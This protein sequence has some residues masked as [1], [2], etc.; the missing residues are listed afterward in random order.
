M[1]SAPPPH[2]PARDGVDGLPAQPEP[3]PPFERLRSEQIYDSRWCGMRRD[4]LRLPSG[5]E[6]EYHVIEITDAVAVVPI[7]AD[8]RIAMIGQY[9]YP[10]G[11]THWEI[12][13]GRMNPSEEPRIAAERELLEE[14]GLR[15]AKMIELPGFYPAN[16]ITDHYAHAFVALDCE[17]VAEPTPDASEQLFRRFFT[18]REVES[19]FDAGR[20]AD[21]F[22][23]L[24]IAY[25][26]RK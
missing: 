3:F 5:A 23:A 24:C 9:R 13:A 25:W 22:T 16:G 15:A 1:S 17:I 20:F 4:V 10:H 18:R 21:A 8:G 11:K 6:Q 19:M 7:L 14:A 12:P 2:D 26:L